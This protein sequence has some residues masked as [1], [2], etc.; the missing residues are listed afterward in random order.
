M[1]EE[2]TVKKRESFSINLWVPERIYH[3]R[4]MLV[5]GKG[6]N[7]GGMDMKKRTGKWNVTTAV[8][9]AAMLLTGC[10]S[11]DKNAVMTEAA[12]DTYDDGGAYYATDDIYAM[13]ETA[14]MEAAAEE[15]VAEAGGSAQ[16]SVEV[17]ESAQT[18]NRKLIKNVDMQVE[19]ETFTE[20]LD[21]IEAKTNALGGYIENS[22]TYNG[23]S[24]Y[25]NTNRDAS[26]TIRI[27]AENLDAFLSAVSEVSN[28]ISRNDR[29]TDITLQYVDLESHKKALQAEQDRLLELMEQAENIEDIITLESRLSEVRY[30]IESMEA[31]LRTYDNQVSYSTVYLNVNEVKQL[32]PV[33]E[34]SVWEKIS[35]GFVESLS[36]V[37][38]GL[39]NFGIGLIIRLPYLI[40]WAVVIFAVVMI[41]KAIIKGRKN[42]KAKKLKKQEKQAQ[43]AFT[44]QAQA[45]FAQQMPAQGSDVQETSVQPAD[46]DTNTEAENGSRE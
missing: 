10:G 17:D 8:L 7:K 31:Q 42:K 32:T 28:V 15:S 3:I 21:T 19:T 27:P 39:L 45:A 44:Q 2:F 4:K 30:Q 13:A 23:S 11:A 12:A 20:L 24:F 5:P 34:Q 40:V 25:G 29:V 36:N 14:E 35:T 1:K 33:K 37:G 9:L 16:E 18:T 6:M 46:G 41:I 43:A 22:Y 38:H 26:L